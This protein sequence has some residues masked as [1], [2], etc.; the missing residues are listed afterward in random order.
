MNNKNGGFCACP[1]CL[2]NMTLVLLAKLI[3]DAGGFIA[4]EIDELR[5]QGET[6][7]GAAVEGGRFIARNMTPSEFERYVEDASH[8]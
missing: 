3:D 2:N 5:K 7:V 6:V 1:N 8:G 4:I